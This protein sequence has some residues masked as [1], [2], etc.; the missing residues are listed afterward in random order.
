MAPQDIKKHY[1]TEQDTKRKNTTHILLLIA[2]WWL[3]MLCTLKDG[4]NKG[5]YIIVNIINLHES[6]GQDN[7]HTIANH[8]GTNL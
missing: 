3:V 5:H 6:T 7:V 1:S 2:A 8:H 4:T